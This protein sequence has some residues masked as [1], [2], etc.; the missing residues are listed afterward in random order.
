V[1]RYADL[2]GQAIAAVTT[3]SDEVRAGIYPGPEHV[4]SIEPG[5]LSELRETLG[6][7]NTSEDQ[8]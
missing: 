5:E 7:I 1:K 3:Y 2:R 6:S 4:Y 8:S